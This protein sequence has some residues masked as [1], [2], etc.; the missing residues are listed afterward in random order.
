V[1]LF[2]ALAVPDSVRAAI[3]SLL[4]ELK[5]LDRSW[6]FVPAENL[7][8]TLNF[9]G[10][11]AMEKLPNVVGALQSAATAGTV[12]LA[13]RGL[14]FFPNERRPRVLWVGMDDRPSLFALAAGVKAALA[15][16]GLPHEERE[17][18]PHLTLARNKTA[19]ITPELRDAIAG[20]ATRQLGTMNASTFHLIES[21]L[22]SSGAEY[23]TL[24]SFRLTR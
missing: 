23:T 14:G 8:V 16:A 24:E 17:F 5:P 7:H 21:K 22:E 20:C 12:T 13:F 9:L 11:V 1:R 19:G 3:A 6:K 18:A 2:V 10:E 4:R 15:G